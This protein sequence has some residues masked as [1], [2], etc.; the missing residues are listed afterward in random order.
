MT[1]SCHFWLSR[2]T[3]LQLTSPKIESKNCHFFMSLLRVTNTIFQLTPLN[4][5]RKSV[6]FSCHFSVSRYKIFR[7]T[8]LNLN[9]KSVVFLCHFSLS[10]S[11]I[12]QLTAPKNEFKKCH[13]IVLLFR[14]AFHDCLIDPT[15]PPN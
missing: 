7:L 15:P 11:T 10:R 13:F 12:F 8:P 4:S 3:I 9:R 6:T 2:F 5:N 1:F 14:A